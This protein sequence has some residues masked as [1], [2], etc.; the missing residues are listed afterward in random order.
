MVRLMDAGP[1]GRE[2]GYWCETSFGRKKV[3]DLGMEDRL[4]AGQ[5]ITVVCGPNARYAIPC[6]DAG[7]LR[8]ELEQYRRRLREH[9]SRLAQTQA[10]TGPR[11]E[12]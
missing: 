6:I 4:A 8:R 12:R 3:Y 2:S 9:Q 1:E 10:D 11:R 5:V 7:P